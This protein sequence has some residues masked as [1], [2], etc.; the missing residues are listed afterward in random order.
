MG[1]TLAYPH[2][3][4]YGNLQYFT[5]IQKLL[6]A[7]VFFKNDRICVLQNDFIDIMSYV[8]K[9]ENPPKWST[10]QHLSGS[11]QMFTLFSNAV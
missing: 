3:H 2:I 10:S 5:L 1:I 7:D 8:M 11:I 6:L 9:A 4:S